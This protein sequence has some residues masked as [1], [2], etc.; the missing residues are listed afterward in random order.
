MRY[1]CNICK[2]DITK[3]EFL[4]SI[5][6]FDKPLC[7]EH[8]DLLRKNKIQ[9]TKINPEEIQKE[10]EDF[11]ELKTNNLDEELIYKDSKNS[12]MSLGKNI[13]LKMGRGIIR[14]ARKV[15][16]FSKKRFQIRKWKS[17]ILLRMTKTQL[18]KLCLEKKINL[19]KTILEEDDSSGEEYWKEVKRTREDLVSIL[20]IRL[21]LDTIISFTK[22]NH[23]DI[24]DILNDIERIKAEWKVKELKDKIKKNGNKILLEVKKVIL[25]FVPFRHYDKEIYYQDTL[26]QF[27][28]SKFPDTKIEVSVG[29]TRPDIVVKGIAIEIKGPTSHK[30][31]V[32]IADK[33][34]RYKQNFPNGLICV[35]FKVNVSKQLYKEW[36]KGLKEYHPDVDVITFP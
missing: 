24:K 36:L 10:Y 27:L 13:A 5:K 25:E 8:Q 19:N 12:Q 26:A 23:I 34:L 1:Y 33:C 20:K 15:V 30:D 11:V 14:S 3:G 35:L 16:R 31:L 18:K 4:Y 6:E 2:K 29:S 28:R 9:L 7:R 22:R 21:K 32:S 17:I